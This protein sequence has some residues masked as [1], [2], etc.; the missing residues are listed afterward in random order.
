MAD[1]WRAAEPR[2]RA[3]ERAC[4]D[5]AWCE[6]ALRPS[7]LRACVVARERFADGLRRLSI[8]PF[9]E[10]RS[11]CDLVLVDTFPLP[12]GGSFTPARRAFERPMAIACFVDA[13]PCFPSRMWSISF[14]SFRRWGILRFWERRLLMPDKETLERA[15]EDAREGKSPSTQA[16]EFVREEYSVGPQLRLP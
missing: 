14:D 16:G 8:R 1:L 15:R 7:F 3:V 12:G 11:A 9:S 13:A 5:N 2:C 10:S 6:A 4:F